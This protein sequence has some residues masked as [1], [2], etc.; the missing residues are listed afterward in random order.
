MS[1]ATFTESVMGIQFGVVRYQALEAARAKGLG[2]NLPEI[3]FHAD[4]TRWVPSD[5]LDLSNELAKNPPFVLHS[6][7]ISDSALLKPSRLHCTE[8]FRQSQC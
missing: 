5:L 8:N 2:T 4:L 7:R 3:V 1:E 6:S